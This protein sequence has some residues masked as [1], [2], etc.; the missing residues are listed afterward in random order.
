MRA[1][2][3]PRWPAADVELADL[4]NGRGGVEIRDQRRVVVHQLPVN[5]FGAA[6]Q[7]IQR[8]RPGSRYLAALIG[9]VGGAQHRV[10]HLPQVAV[11]DVRVGKSVGNDFSLLGDF[12]AAA[13][14]P[15][16]LGQDRLVGRAAAA[17][18]GAAAPVKEG[19]CDT[20]PSANSDQR[21]LR[22]MQRPVGRQ[23]P[24]VLVGIAVADHYLLAHAAS[25]QMRQI[26]RI[27]KQRLHDRSGVLQI[28]DG[29]KQRHNVKRVGDAGVLRQQQ[30]DQNIAR[31]G[32]H[33]DDVGVDGARPETLVRPPDQTEQFHHLVCLRAEVEAG[34]RQRARV[35]EFGCQ[36][37]VAL[38]FREI[39][40]GR[41]QAVAAQQLG[42]GAGM[43]LG[44][45]ADV[46]RR[47]METESFDLGD[48]ILQA[49]ARHARAA[50]L[51]EAV[52]H[53][54]QILQEL[55]G[56]AVFHRMSQPVGAPGPAA[57]FLGCQQL[58]VDK[59]HLLAIG[60]AGIACSKALR[61][62]GKQRGVGGQAGAQLV[63]YAEAFRGAEDAVHR[64][65]DAAVESQR[66][67]FLGAQRLL[68]DRERDKGIAVAVA[69]HP[70]ADVYKRR[71]VEVVPGVGFCQ[72]PPHFDVQLRRQFEKRVLDVVEAVAHFVQHR[73]L[74]GARFIGLPEGRYFLGDEVD[75]G[76]PLVRGQRDG[77]QLVQLAGDARQLDHD[78][79]A[80]G[81]GGMGGDDGHD[82][83]PVKKLLNLAR[84]DALTLQI[85]DG[86]RDGFAHRVAIA[87]IGARP[88]AQRTHARLLF[89]QVDKL[90]VGG[91]CLH[92]PVGLVQRQRLYDLLQGRFG[93]LIALAHGLGQR[94]HLLDAVEECLPLL[95]DEY[96]AEHV[97]QEMNL[98][99]DKFLLGF[100]DD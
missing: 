24:A 74:V 71:E 16:R 61:L 38:V 58:L 6:R 15:G 70:T 39:A 54:A 94:A 30:N 45:L 25:A 29:L 56:R 68:G 13:H 23:E 84:G 82:Q 87:V 52:L 27:G 85:H 65:D 41:H 48:Q 35:V 20:V 44:M 21:T 100:H 90:E 57:A 40:V 99:A 73:R 51:R 63:R 62:D 53:Q 4:G 92:D 19:Q 83:Q 46:Q 98:L 9:A 22:A 31:A 93:G 81:L 66:Q 80:L 26:N 1:G 97:A 69:A 79:T 95:F 50:V 64:V 12:D 7:L 88:V 10:A 91:K 78:C 89:G 32:G 59:R 18:D 77:V 36:Q 55:P 42:H 60:L 67:C 8:T 28:A 3:A 72:R 76:G 75:S 49:A 34:G 5:N 17:P 37:V 14:R 86:R 33:A 43:A 2:L 96:L 11:G 47:Q